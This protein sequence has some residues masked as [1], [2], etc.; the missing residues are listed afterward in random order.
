MY[1]EGAV[2]TIGMWVI[3]ARTSE[4][5]LFLRGET[6]TPFVAY[7]SQAPQHALEGRREQA[8]SG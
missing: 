6:I 8:C 2:L 4:L 7:V 3:R 5:M 1:F